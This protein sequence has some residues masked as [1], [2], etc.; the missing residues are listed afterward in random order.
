MFISN[1]ERL[2]NPK[3]SR[4]LARKDSQSSLAEALGR[5][6]ANLNQGRVYADQ[7]DRFATMLKESSSYS[8]SQRTVRVVFGEGSDQI[9]LNISRS[10]Y[11]LEIPGLAEGQSQLINPRIPLSKEIR[12]DGYGFI[13]EDQRGR[14]F[15]F[16][17]DAKINGRQ[18]RLYPRV[19]R[20]VN[21]NQKSVQ[22]LPDLAQA[23]D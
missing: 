14:E 20:V 19:W 13:L 11:R 2:L 18:S 5:V 4:L 7:F 10:G 23:A 22:A 8:T 12:S 3:P 6:F 16:M 21:P 9:G 1:K 15:H 17:V